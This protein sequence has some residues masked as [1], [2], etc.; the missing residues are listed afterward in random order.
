MRGCGE[1]GRLSA[2]PVWTLALLHKFLPS[3]SRAH[4]TASRDAHQVTAIG[5][6]ITQVDVAAGVASH[7]S[8]YLS[9]VAAA[10][11]WAG[12]TLLHLPVV[13]PR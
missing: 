13:A 1:E 7:A 5:R 2:P 3:R 6:Y 8:V 12:R 11:D 10:R 4:Y 9:V